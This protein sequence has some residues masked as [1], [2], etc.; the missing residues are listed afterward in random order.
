VRGVAGDASRVAWLVQFQQSQPQLGEPEQ[1]IAGVGE[2]IEVL[3][4]QPRTDGDE[5]LVVQ[6]TAQARGLVMPRGGFLS[7]D[8]YGLQLFA[9]PLTS[10][11]FGLLCVH[12]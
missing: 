12:E 9:E 10:R 3:G 1:V 2:E 11:I 5:T 8:M 6:Q 7:T 4:R